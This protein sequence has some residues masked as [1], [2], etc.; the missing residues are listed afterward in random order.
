VSRRLGFDSGQELEP[1]AVALLPAGL[2]HHGDD[3]LAAGAGSTLGVRTPASARSA[4]I[5]ASSEAISAGVWYP[6]RCT[7][8]TEGPAS[9][10]SIR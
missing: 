8:S 6:S 4:S 10:S 1:H 9:G 2:V 5:Q 3:A 7:C